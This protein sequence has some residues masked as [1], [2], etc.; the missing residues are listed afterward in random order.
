ME[1][2]NLPDLKGLATL[3]AVVELGGVE[4]A[5]HSLNVGQPA[6]TKRLRA[7][8][9]CYGAQLMQREGRRLELTRAGERVYAFASLVLDHQASVMDDLKHL[10]IGKNQLRL[11]ATF[12]IGEHLLPELLLHFARSYPQYGIQ[13]RMGYS[14][15]IQTR[16]ATGL[17]DIALLEHATDHPDI[18]V[19]KWLDDELLLVCGKQHPLAKQGAVSLNQLTELDFVLREPRSSMRIQLDSALADAGIHSLPVAM[20]VGSTDAIVEMLERSQ[21]VSFLPGFAVR[22]ALDDGELFHLEVAELDIKRSLWIAQSRANLHNPVTEAFI[23]VLRE[24]KTSHDDRQE[25]E[26]TT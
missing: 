24:H 19:Q 15:R 2:E 22:E 4:Q 21:H 13:S 16:L 18:L 3:K 9:R 23:Q 17:S 8:E 6:I 25:P 10:N 12:S 14:R 20:E 26:S 7:L 1:Y 5:G 11:E